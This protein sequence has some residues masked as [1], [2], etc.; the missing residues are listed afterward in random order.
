MQIQIT[1]KTNRFRYLWLKGVTGFIPD[2]CCAKSLAGK[3]AKLVP[4]GPVKAG[5]SYCGD[6]PANVPF[7]Y[8]CGV[9]PQY[10]E[11]LHVAI[12]PAQGKQVT[13]SDV[14]CD[15]VISDAEQVFIKPVESPLA[16]KEQRSCRNYQFGFSQFKADH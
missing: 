3:Y 15:V 16:S 6:L 1:I 5:A 12:R 9:T 11:N 8:L 10:A 13:Y 4:F 2:A 7:Y 14:N